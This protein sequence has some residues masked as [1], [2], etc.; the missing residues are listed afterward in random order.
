MNT[1]YQRL[2]ESPVINLVWLLL[3]VASASIGIV[4][5]VI[6]VLAATNVQI[7]SW[8]IGYILTSGTNEAIMGPCLA[9]FVV[10]LVVFVLCM[11][12][13]VLL[14]ALSK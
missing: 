2:K 14:R 1:T 3:I 6:Y 7:L 13:N 5:G 12:K 8:S 4:T 11:C 10:S 9:A